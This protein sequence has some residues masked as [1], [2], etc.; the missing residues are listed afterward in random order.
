[1]IILQAFM[2]GINISILR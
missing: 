1:M 2:Q